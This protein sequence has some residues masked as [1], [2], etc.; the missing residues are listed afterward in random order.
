M[1]E[2]EQTDWFFDTGPTWESPYLF[3]C[4]HFADEIKSVDESSGPGY[5]VNF[6]EE[7]T[8]LVQIVQSFVACEFTV[9]YVLAAHEGVRFISRMSI[10][11]KCGRRRID[12]ERIR[13]VFCRFLFRDVGW[14]IGVFQSGSHHLLGI[15]QVSP[16]AEPD[17][18]ERWQNYRSAERR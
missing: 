17:Q 8:V 9:S 10:M 11:S 12:D 15:S 6:Q 13:S 16:S 7:S 3:D 18:M 1:L 4:K 5:S 14:V 2:Q